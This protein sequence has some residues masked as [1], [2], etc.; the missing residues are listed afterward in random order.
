MATTAQDDALLER[1]RERYQLAEDGWRDIHTDGAEDMRYVAGDPWSAE[2]KAQRKEANRPA[3]ALDEL[4][5]Y[6]NQ[7]INDVRSN[8]RGVRFSATGDG[9]SDESATFY[10]DKMRE[11]EYR[12]NAQIA[13]TSAFENAVQRGYGFCRVNTEF[14]SPRS[15]DQDIIIQPFPN[16]DMVL[17]DPTSLRPDSS[18]MRYCFV[19]EH[20][21][22][23]DFTREF[24]ADAA[25]QDF[26][27]LAMDYPRWFTDSHVMLAEYWEIEEVDD[28]LHQF[29]MPDGSVLG[30]L[31]SEI[32][33]QS[34]LPALGLSAWPESIQD[35]PV[36]IPS[37]AQYLTNGAEILSTTPWPGKHI[38]IASCYGKVIYVTGGAGPERKLMSMTRLARDPYMLY[39]YY[40]TTQAELVGMTP[41]TP[42]IGYEGQFK[43]HESEWSKVQHTPV[44]YLQA[45]AMTEGSSG[46]ILPLPQ[47]Q[48]YSPAIDQL[49]FGAEGARRAIQAAMGVSPLPSSAQR[50]N[51]KSGVALQQIEASSQKGTYHFV[52]NFD[53]MLRQIGV[54]AED[55]MGSTYDTPR[56]VG[57][58]GANDEARTVRINDEEMTPTATQKKPIS[59]RGDHQVTIS[60]G[61]AFESQ[62][63]AASD[64]AD[65]LAGNPD[66]FRLIGPMIIKLKNL[67]PIGDEIA[68][69][70]KFLQP[71]E[72]RQPEEGEEP[73]PAQLQRQLMEGQQLLQQAQAQIQELTMQVETSAMKEQAKTQREA[74][75]ADIKKE[76]ALMLQTMK[77]E[78][79]I[80]L[81][82][83][84]GEEALA[85]QDDAQGH[86]LGLSAVHAA[87]TRN[88][89]RSGDAGS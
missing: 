12:S 81:A 21:R 44:A 78:Q 70:L 7:V 69:A 83:T 71:P 10:Q 87:E 55:L 5:Q 18:D 48:P 84:Q 16:P 75:L 35:R 23:E 29:Q 22:R 26:D 72:M 33:D 68:E 74:M 42:Y 80:A 19:H 47:R 43:G 77:G 76:L 82:R 85:L 53:H 27:A 3:L 9:A 51:E 37:V 31:K 46:Q 65:Q 54:I 15:F 57:V 39:C 38:P 2:D 30:V 8:P 59:T 56:D 34:L 25:H 62:R 67:G 49:E 11:I 52:D 61:P 14:T 40:R 79:A 88:T 58:I 20:W 4:G 1:I 60:T 36:R 89:Q 32:E 66:V 50:R 28:V 45:K 41:K 73:D 63:Q 24:G 17:P 86:E 13:Y 64:F 6:F